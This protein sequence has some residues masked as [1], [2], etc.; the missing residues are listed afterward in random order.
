[1]AFSETVRINVLSQIT[2]PEG[3]KQG[4]T[5]DFISLPQGKKW[6]GSKRW[7]GEQI[8]ESGWGPPPLLITPRIHQ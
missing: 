2:S 5:Q 7:C 6:C 4:W 3:H 8:W 1:M